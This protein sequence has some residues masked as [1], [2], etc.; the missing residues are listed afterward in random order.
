MTINLTQHA[1]TPD[2]VAAGVVD[3]DQDAKG[4]LI[5]LLTVT[6]GGPDGLLSQADPKAMLIERAYRIADLVPKGTK[7]AMV[8]GFPALMEYLVPALQGR[9]VTPLY[10][11]SERVTV[12]TAGP[13]GAVKK[14]AV[15]QHVGFLPAR[16]WPDWPEPE[17]P[18]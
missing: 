2:Q 4:V 10:A 7:A 5:Q 1:A 13:D 9:G 15:F 18:E 3:L 14:T 16:L 12:E 6:I 8:G 17:W 11:L